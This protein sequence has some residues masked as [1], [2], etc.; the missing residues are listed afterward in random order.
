MC[1]TQVYIR[2]N[3]LNSKSA[4]AMHQSHCGAL[5]PFRTSCYNVKICGN[6][7]GGPCFSMSTPSDG[8]RA[9]AESPCLR[10]TTCRGGVQECPDLI[11]CA[12]IVAGPPFV[13]ARRWIC[14]EAWKHRTLSD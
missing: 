5:H 10:G 12:T 4:H 14:E 3:P 7:H 11:V 13:V 9:C 8:V 2:S 1:L 6:L